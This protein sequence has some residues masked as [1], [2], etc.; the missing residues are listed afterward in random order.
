MIKLKITDYIRFALTIYLL[1]V[2]WGNSH[3]SVAIAIT[4]LTITSELTTA[5]LQ[6]IN[7]CVKKIAK[8]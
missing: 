4:L 2:V 5:S 1:Y 8:I 6:L 7:Q 3:M